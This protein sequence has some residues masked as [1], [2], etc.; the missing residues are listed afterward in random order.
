[1]VKPQNSCGDLFQRLQILPLPCEYIFSFLNF[2]ISNQEH[3]QANS[4]V[5]SVNARNKHHLHRPIANL[6]VFQKSTHYSGIKIFSTLPF[7]L[8]R[9]MNEKAKF[10]EAL[11]RDLYTQSF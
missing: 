4:A 10:K 7:S 1:V 6:T 3:F 2:I 5:H 9:L 8:K 11:N